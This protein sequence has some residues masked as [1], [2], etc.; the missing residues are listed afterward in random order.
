MGSFGASS[1]SSSS[2][3]VGGAA[4]TGSAALVL[5]CFFLCTTGWISFCSADSSS[6]RERLRGVDEL[7]VEEVMVESKAAMVSHFCHGNIMF[8]NLQSL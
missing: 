1:S 7:V 4:A 8:T 6:Q 2:T 3:V 5:R